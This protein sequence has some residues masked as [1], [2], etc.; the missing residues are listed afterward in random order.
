M[1][2]ELAFT[3]PMITFVIIVIFEISGA[4]M[5]RFISII[6]TLAFLA[7]CADAHAQF[8]SPPPKRPPPLCPVLNGLSYS[9]AAA[10]G[11]GVRCAADNLFETALKCHKIGQSARCTADVK[12]LYNGVWISLAPVPNKLIYDWAFI[13]DGQEYYLSPSNSSS[14]LISCGLYPSITV[15]VTAA[16]KT[17]LVEAQCD[18]SLSEP[19]VE[20]P[21]APETDF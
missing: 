13:V 14:I 20:P 18:S 5:N 6:L 21:V 17:S 16:D 7:F 12:L 11:G 3:D 9:T 4:A 2:G 15:R 19:P 8:T 10:T 1:A